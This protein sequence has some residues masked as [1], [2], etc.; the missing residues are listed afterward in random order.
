MIR[1]IKPLIALH[2][3]SLLI[4][5]ITILL[6][7][8]IAF[9]LGRKAYKY[10]RYSCKISC[11]KYFLVQFKNID[12]QDPKR[13]AYEATKYGMYLARDK[14]Q[15]EIFNQLRVR[16]DRYKYK[17]NISKVDEETM[18]YYNLYVQVCDESL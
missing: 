11:Q 4:F 10:A 12:W 17:Q 1:D 3:L 6:G 15:K 5:V 8:L 7:I 16:L 2:D 14:R 18:R 9:W 13:A